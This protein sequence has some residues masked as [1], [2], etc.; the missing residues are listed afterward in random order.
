VFSHAFNAGGPTVIAAPIK[1]E[2]KP[3]IPIAAADGSAENVAR[4][5]AGQDHLHLVNS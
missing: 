3:L 1:R 4:G 5:L 2:L